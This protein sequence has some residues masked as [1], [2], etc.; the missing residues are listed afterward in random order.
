MTL[1]SRLGIVMIFS[2]AILLF[3]EASPCLAQSASSSSSVIDEHLVSS[4]AP[5]LVA[6]PD[7]LTADVPASSD[8]E[9]ATPASSALRSRLSKG[10]HG[11]LAGRS[12]LGL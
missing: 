11:F 6:T 8:A 1:S 5:S 3:G 7:P 12:G 2:I 10:G 9:V 4:S